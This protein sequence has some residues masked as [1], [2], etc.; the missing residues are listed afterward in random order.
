MASLAGGVTAVFALHRAAR[1]G[2]N[3]LLLTLF[4]LLAGIAIIAAMRTW[5]ATLTVDGARLVLPL[6]LDPASRW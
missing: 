1:A 5:E 4:G 2:E 6:P 3:H